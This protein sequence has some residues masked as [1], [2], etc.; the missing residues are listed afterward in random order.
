MITDA[1][2]G[3]NLTAKIE[4]ISPV[5][6]EALFNITERHQHPLILDIK[7]AIIEAIKTCNNT[8]QLVEG[9]E[10]RLLTSLTFKSNQ[11]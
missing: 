9:Y 6:K 7:Y 1:F 10:K 3:G 11:S 2:I 5:S 4:K 8:K